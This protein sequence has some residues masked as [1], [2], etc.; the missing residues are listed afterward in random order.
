[1][2]IKE[3][4]DRWMEKVRKTKRE[5]AE[6]FHRIRVKLDFIDAWFRFDWSAR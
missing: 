3:I 6:S 1:M 4:D 5:T 2:T